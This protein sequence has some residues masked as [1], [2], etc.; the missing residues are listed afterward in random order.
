MDSA[1]L[2]ALTFS[3]IPAAYRS[4]NALYP[5]SPSAGDLATGN[6]IQGVR[7]VGGSYQ[8]IRWDRTTS[9]WVDFASPPVSSPVPLGRLVATITD[10]P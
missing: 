9:A 10:C 6:E 3:G 8:P 1:L 2:P 5:S 7:V 4:P